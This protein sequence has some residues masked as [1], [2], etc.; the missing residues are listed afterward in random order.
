[1]E[2]GQGQIAPM[3]SDSGSGNKDALFGVVD[4]CW[5]VAFIMEW[6]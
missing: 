1:M 4:Y 6:D 5:A 2:I 3:A